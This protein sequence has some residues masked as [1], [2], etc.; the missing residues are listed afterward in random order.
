[1]RPSEARLSSAVLADW[2][3]LRSRQF[4]KRKSYGIQGGELPRLFGPAALAGWFPL[5]TVRIPVKWS[6]DSGDVGQHR[7][8]AT[9]GC[10]YL[11]E[12]DHFSQESGE[13]ECNHHHFVSWFAV[14]QRCIP[15]EAV[16]DSV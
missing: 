4:Q 14:T 6:G 13:M 10:S 15:V 7:S 3:K 5:S 2:L 16:H 11:S 12:V 1:M 9:L 8:E